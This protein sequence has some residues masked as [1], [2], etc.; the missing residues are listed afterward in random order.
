MLR[1]E[2]VVKHHRRTV[3]DGLDLHVERGET[4]AVVGA[5]G[6]GK[7]T[8]LRLAAT[9]DRPTS[10]RVL[11]DGH[12]TVLDGE[13]ARAALGWAGDAPGLFGELTVAANLRAAA[14][15]RA[16]PRAA[17]D[18]ALDA[19]G[20]GSVADLRAARLSRGWAQRAALARAVVGDPP[21][22]LLDE[23]AANLDPDGRARLD[24][25]LAARSAAGLT[26][27]LAAPEPH[28]AASRVVRLDGGRAA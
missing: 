19:L 12:H 24:A 21:L 14:D 22:L 2:A 8:L 23:P 17:A 1:F 3:L 7:T 25:V 18:A 9:L 20:L 27:V 6:S 4:V 15:L 16:R 10:G 26:T 28:P 11:V 13:R 5:N